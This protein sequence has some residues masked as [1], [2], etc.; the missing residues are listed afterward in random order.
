MTAALQQQ[1]CMHGHG[2]RIGTAHGR[3]FD[4]LVFRLARGMMGDRRVCVPRLDGDGSSAAAL[5][6]RVG[7]IMVQGE[8]RIVVAALA[9]FVALAGMAISVHGL[10]YGENDV[11][12]SGAIAVGVGV[13]ACVAML[14]LH[15]KDVESHRHRES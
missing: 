4:V 5:G 2:N 1:A 14:T 9:T 12:L 15:P 11:M 13:A 3:R 6:R 7:G 8:L 10:L